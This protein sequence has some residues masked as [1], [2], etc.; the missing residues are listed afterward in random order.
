MKHLRKSLSNQN[1][2]QDEIRENYI[3]E[4]LLQFDSEYFVFI[5]TVWTQGT[6][7]NM[8]LR[9]VLSGY[10]TLCLVLQEG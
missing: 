10:K 4:S 3:W 8:F 5:L 2:M 6:C 9:D 1:C 7:W